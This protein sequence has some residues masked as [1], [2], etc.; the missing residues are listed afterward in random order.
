MY[1]CP[2]CQRTLQIS[3]QRCTACHFA[4]HVGSS[5]SILVDG[6]L[7]P[8]H[9]HNEVE[10]AWR[11]G[12]LEFYERDVFINQKFM[13]NFTLPLLG[14]LFGK[15]LDIRILSVGCGVGADVKLLRDWGYDAW[16][17]DCGSRS[18]FWPSLSSPEFLA[19]CT[20]QHLPFASETFDFVMC[21]QV[22]EHIG[23]VGDSMQLVDNYRQRR[24]Q[25]VANIMRVVSKGGYLNIATPN[26]L[27][28]LDPGH[29]PNFFGIRIHGPFDHFLTSYA[30]MRRYLPK[31]D[32]TPVTPLGYYAG[33]FASKTGPLGAAFESYLRLLDRYPALQGTFLNPLTNV[34]ARKR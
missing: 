3:E 34:L 17:T 14:R 6:D 33:T 7:Y 20:D 13:E 19:R 31:A 1:V 29:A 25:F 22:L 12:N 15:R 32:V 18:I 26:R 10:L 24:E 27:F 5:G 21:H 11:L 4:I 16:G 30:D 28:P 2:A 8:D 9:N 23:V